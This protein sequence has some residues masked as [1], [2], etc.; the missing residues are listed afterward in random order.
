MAEKIIDDMLFEN[1]KFTL[2]IPVKNEIDG[3]KQI[4]PKIDSK[5]IDDILILDG[6]SV[7]GSFEY[8]SKMGYNV[9]RQNSI[10]IKAAFWEAFEIINNDVIIPFSPDGNSIPEDIPRLVSK[11]KE[12]FD[13]VVASRYKN[14]TL[15]EDD[16]LPSALAN[17]Y[18][19]KLINIL[20]NSNLT[21][22]LGMYKAFYKKHLFILK[23]DK[24]RNEHSEIMLLTRG[25]RYGLNITEIISPE[26][27][28][29]GV[30]GS[31]AHPGVFGKY[32]SGILI[33]KTIIR[34]A[35][36]YKPLK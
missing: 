3:L 25:S 22:G 31:R 34:D 2:F 29:I 23:I 27:K 19:T 4:M 5:W 7:D 36:F 11:I 35:L 33:L 18:L 24:V 21:D 1:I 28:R 9:M 20:F 14:N 15:S 13:I 32:K 30:S 17:R 26:P 10:G 6:N 12:G 16:D 8:L